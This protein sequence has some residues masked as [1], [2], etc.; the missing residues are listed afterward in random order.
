MYK[1]E[2]LKDELQ[3]MNPYIEVR[4]DTVRITEEN[5]RDLFK[6]DDIICEAFDKPDVKAM[7]TEQILCYYPEKTLICGSGMAGYG[8]SNT[9]KTRKIND[10]FIFAGWRQRR[11]AGQRTDGARV[12]ICAAHEAIWFCAAFLVWMPMRYRRIRPVQSNEDKI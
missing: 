7:L 11:H 12:T 3:R 8:S 1:T 9:I 2:A 4:I 5:C 6:D 10:H